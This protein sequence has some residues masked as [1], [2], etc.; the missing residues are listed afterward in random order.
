VL[1]P[2]FLTIAVTA[3]SGNSSSDKELSDIRA[4][5]TD[6]R[7]EM[8]AMRQ[9]IR[10]LRDELHKTAPASEE[11]QAAATT[12]PPAAAASEPAPSS[13]PAAPS[14]KAAKPPAQGSVNIEVESNPAGATVFLADKKVGETPI[15]LKAPVGTHE[16]NVR[17]E[18]SGYRPRLMTLR[19]EEDTK[20]SVQL[21]KK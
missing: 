3:C 18:K 19:P 9:E 2:L 10:E 8:R 13:S 12:E 14:S 1:R 4:E 5:L 6:Q 16:I 17:L 11:P 15:M 20:I 7:A 21:A